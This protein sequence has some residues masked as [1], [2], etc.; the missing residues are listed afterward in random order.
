M[1][2]ILSKILKNNNFL[3]LTG[4]VTAAALGFVSFAILARV[5]NKSD[6]GNLMIFITLCTFFDL[7]R[8]GFLQT[9]LIKFTSGATEEQKREV[10]GTAWVFG[11]LITVVVGSVSLLIYIF[12]KNYFTNQGFLYFLKLVCILSAATLPMNFAT[13]NL[14]SD[15]KFNRI[16][17]IRWINLGSFVALLLLNYFYFH[18]GIDFIIYSFMASQIIASVVC[19]ACKWTKIS[20]LKYY[21]KSRMKDISNFGKYSMSTMIG[22]NL[23]RSSDTFMI[24]AFLSPTAVAMYSVPAK[25]F[26]IVEIPLRSF[27]ATA[28]PNLSRLINNKDSEG[29]KHLF[30][31]YAGVVTV[32]LI[33]FVVGSFIFAEY[34]VILLGG[35]QYADASNI[36]RIFAVFALLMP[37]DRY[38]GVTLD[39]LNLP[40]KNFLK[41]LLMLMVKIAGNFIVIFT[42]GEVWAVAISSIFT[43]ASGVILGVLFLKKSLDFSMKRLLRRGYAESKL[44]ALKSL[45]KFNTAGN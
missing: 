22:S 18:K 2:S 33:P 8:T 37:L 10:I 45:N 38:T 7:L 1:K 9:P 28:L 3:S 19:I 39:V 24:G 40:V 12:L 25:L 26:E 20:Y 42:I 5:L 36:L 44:F 41:V 35:K 11:L 6:F 23:L 29:L 27:V 43:F 34:L 16:I 13:W 15:M 30:E 31:K 21:S 4:N 17:F 14:Q 32:M